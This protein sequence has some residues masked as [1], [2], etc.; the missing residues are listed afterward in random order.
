MTKTILYRGG[1]LG[2]KYSDIERAIILPNVTRIGFEAFKN[3]KYLKSVFI[4]DSVE[5]I[6]IDAFFG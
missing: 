6:E 1:K 2:P 3:A 4:P 5:T